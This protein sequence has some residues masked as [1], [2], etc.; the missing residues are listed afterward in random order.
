MS[1]DDGLRRQIRDDFRD[2][3]RRHRTRGERIVVAVEASPETA[4]ARRARRLVVPLGESHGS[5]ILDRV[6]C[7][8]AA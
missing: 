8:A 7:G 5:N 4:P 6:A 2:A 3:Q 1:W